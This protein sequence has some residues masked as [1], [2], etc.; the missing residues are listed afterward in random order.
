[1]PEGATVVVGNYTF[2]ISY[3]GG[4]NDQSVV[5]TE[6]SAPPVNYP[7]ANDIQVSMGQGQ[8]ATIDLVGNSYISNG[9]TL[10]ASIVTQPSFGSVSFNAGNGLWDYTPASASYTG[11]DSFTYQVSTSGGQKSNVAVV[12]IEVNPVNQAP[13]GTSN[14]VTTDEN[15]PYTFSEADF[16]FSDPNKPPANFLAVKI[17]S[18]PAAGSL[19]DDGVAV[20]LDQFVSVA[21]IDNGNLVFTPGPDEFG[22][23]YASFDFAVQDDGSTAY[24]GQTIDPNPKT[25]TVDVLFVNQGPVGADNTVTTL[26]NIPYAF[27]AADF[28]FS[29]PT[30]KPPFIFSGVVITTLPAV[31]TLTDNGSDVTAGSFVSVSDINN[32]LLVYTPPSDTSGDPYDSFTFQVRDDGGTANGGTDTDPIPKTMTIDVTL[33]AQQS[34]TSGSSSPSSPSLGQLVTITATVAAVPP[35][36]ATPTGSVDFTD[37]TT[38]ND[39]GTSPLI[40]GSAQVTTNELALGNN[41]ITLTYSGDATFATSATTITIT[42]VVA[43]Y[44]MSGS[45]NGAL[46]LSGSASIDIPGVLEVNSGSSTAL[47]LAGTAS[48]AASSIQIVGGYHNTGSGGITPTP[49]PAPSVAD[50]LAYLPVPSASTNPSTTGLMT[51]GAVVY[52]SGSHTL[53]PGIY[54]EILLEGSASATLM[55]GL[56]VIQGGGV[57]VEGSASITGSGVV[58]YNTSNPTTGAFG[59]FL[60]MSTSTLSAPTSGTY[61]GVLLFQDRS[62]TKADEILAGTGNSSAAF[63]LSGTVYAFEAPLTISAH[64]AI[65]VDVNTLTL[66]GTAVLQALA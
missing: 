56:Y 47:S 5:L 49:T 58:F 43:D 24:N 1:M 48:V 8:T 38:G 32:D 15:A 6:Q 51:Y 57:T 29:D 52:S 23:S 12:S 65:A 27:A 17:A 42:T 55:P 61:A 10:T 45:A 16:G 34:S 25:M 14:T 50:P 11:P 35:G 18:L 4:N 20:S 26:E 28:G 2:T 44:V 40:G 7:V 46:S 64:V 19:T 39:L 53:Y 59:S 3:Q 63:N 36:A 66:G 22:A 9:A 21:D 54:S 41:S 62:D 37:T 31:G 30:N 60:L 13:R 33:V